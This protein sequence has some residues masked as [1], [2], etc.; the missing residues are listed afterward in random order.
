[1]T[2]STVG[3]ERVEGWVK[4]M[5]AGTHRTVVRTI[6]WAV[7]CV[8]LA[9]RVTPAALARA[10]PAEHGGSGRARLTRVQRWRAGPALD[11]T[12]VSPALIRPALA[13]RAAVVGLP[14]EALVVRLIG[15]V[16]VASTLQMQLGRRVST[17]EA[18]RQRRA[19]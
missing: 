10:L 11:Q 6:A 7:P 9:Q 18:G 19:Q 13:L 8:L 1:V 5:L 14:T 15:V 2:A 16:C 3:Y 4:V 17:D 12:V